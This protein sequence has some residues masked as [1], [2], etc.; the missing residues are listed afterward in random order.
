M[1][2]NLQ[3]IAARDYAFICSHS[4]AARHQCVTLVSALY[5]TAVTR[6][7]D[8]ISDTGNIYIQRATS[9]RVTKTVF[10]LLAS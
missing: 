7:A 8:S 6:V 9:V 10:V 2:L 3:K 5:R 1:A 4:S